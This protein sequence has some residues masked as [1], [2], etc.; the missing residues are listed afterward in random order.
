MQV[1]LCST[2]CLKGTSPPQR[3]SSPKGVVSPYK[4]GCWLGTLS[5]GSNK[6]LKNSYQGTP[7]G[8]SPSCLLCFYISPTQRIS[9]NG[10]IFSRKNKQITI[11]TKIRFHPQTCSELLTRS[12][13]DNSSRFTFFGDFTQKH[14]SLLVE[15]VC[16]IHQAE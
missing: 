14:H 4:I 8:G 2:M 15:H 13:G 11:R 3:I 9:V 5:H 1:P 6:F 12:L 7:T 10:S 16:I